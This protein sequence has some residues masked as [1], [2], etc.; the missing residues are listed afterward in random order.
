V[1]LLYL[2]RVPQDRLEHFQARAVEGEPLPWTL[3]L[4]DAKHGETMERAA[5]QDTARESTAQDS[6]S[7]IAE[8]NRTHDI[9]D[10]LRRHGYTPK[11]R[12]R[13]LYSKSSSGLP[14]VRL[15]SETG[16]IY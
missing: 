6:S 7:V 9:G 5:R 15:L 2:P 10:L 14:G 16:K 1:H 13:W 3:L 4:E 12:R 11:P 8:F